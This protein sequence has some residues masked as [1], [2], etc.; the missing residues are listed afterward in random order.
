MNKIEDL[1]PG[2]ETVAC[3]DEKSGRITFEKGGTKHDNGKP[4]LSLLPLPGLSHTARAFEFGMHKYGRSNYRKG[5]E[6]HRLIGAAL[7]HIYAW[8]EGE[9]LDPESKAHHL[10][11]A[12]ATLLMLMT[13]EHDK[14]MTDT[15]FKGSK[16]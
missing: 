10:G 4:D 5:F 14:T 7:R 9:D 8:N 12:V 3:I 2:D 6:S 11:H 15:R 13:N 16:K 1:Y